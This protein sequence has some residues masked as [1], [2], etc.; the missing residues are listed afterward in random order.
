[1]PDLTRRSLLATAALPLVPS[2]AQGWAATLQARAAAL[3][4]PGLL[5]SYDVSGTA[6][7]F[8]QTQAG[9]AYVYDNAVA[10]L[11]L[12]AAGDPAGARKIGD[13]LRHAQAHDRFWQDGRLR[14]AYRAGPAPAQGAY[15]LP[16]WW[17]AAA[18]LWTEDGYQ[19]GTATGN[20]AWAMLLWIA[21]GPDYRPAAE[22]AADW[23]ERQLRTPRGYAGGVL[24]FE[25]TP[26]RLTWVST[27]H[28]ID[29]AAAFTAMGRPAA[30][31]HARSLV[32][33]MWQPGEGRFATGLTPDGQV[34]L[35]SAV[36]ANLWPLLAAGAAPEW[37][38]ALDWVLARQGLPA[39]G[40]PALMDGVDFDTDRDG[41][42]LEGTAIT[43][44]AA[45][46]AG[47]PAARLLATLRAHT[48]PGGL[49]YACTT[50]TLTT[51]L[52]TGLDAHAPDFLYYRRPHL[53]P[54]AWAA[55][56]LLGANPFPK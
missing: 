43:A 17:D 18:Q 33:S 24:G 54:T 26:Q 29:L 23:V 1:M 10:A 46:R 34:N 55:L 14:N 22:R 44:L 36:D 25:P 4:G 16:G 21:L 53:A 31:A 41:I 50:P 51:G 30:T 2:P 6:D 39:D 11:A 32:T 42:W 56:A 27:E 35:H 8:A 47:R 15:P 40:P 52:S 38:H 19:V 37:A 49:I 12:L 3:S 9:C 13:A 7:A 45:A 20:V 48:A 28:N 5:Q